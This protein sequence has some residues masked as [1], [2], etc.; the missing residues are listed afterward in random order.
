VLIRSRPQLVGGGIFISLPLVLIAVTVSSSPARADEEEDTEVVEIRAERV[1][2][3]SDLPS[4]LVTVVEAEDL[5]P[6]MVTTSMMAKAAPAAR[7]REFGGPGQQVTV[8]L[9]GA[10]PHQTR[11]QIDGVPLPDPIGTGVD[12][13]FIPAAFIERLEVLRGAASLQAGSGALGGVVN[14]ITPTE[15]VEGFFGRLSAGSYNTFNVSAGT[16]FES[17]RSRFLLAAS[18]LST[19]G[20]FEYLDNRLTEY[21]PYDDEWRAREN[22]DVLR[23]GLLFKGAARLGRGAELKLT[24]QMVAVDRGVAGLQGFTAEAARE[25]GWSGL[26]DLRAR[27]P[28]ADASLEAGAN[29]LLTGQHFEDPRG[30]LTGAPIDSRQE[31]RY[32]EAFSSGMLP[33]GQS[34]LLRLRLAYRH[35]GL[36]DATLQD[37]DRH[38]ICASSGAELVLLSDTV[39]I[40]PAV[41][42]GYVTGAGFQWA[43]ALGA[44]AEVAERLFLRVNLARAYRVP[45]FSEL[46][47]QGGQAVGNPDL[48][49]ESVWSADAGIEWTGLDNWRFALAGFYSRYFDLIVFE[50]SSNFRYRPINVGQAEMGGLEWEVSGEVAEGL[51]VSGHYTLL[52][53]ADRT[54]RPNRE[55]KELPGRPRH[56]AGLRAWGRWRHLL[57]EADVYFVSSNFVNQANT[58]ELSSRLLIDA[59]IGVD[60][61]RGMKVMLQAKNLLDDQVNDVRGLPLPGIS[62]FITVGITRGGRT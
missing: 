49:P 56:T 11:V 24:H 41:G 19:S 13:S 43:P 51:E 8:G 38:E 2:E 52:L 31:G 16:A 42:V 46:Y 32:L 21:N 39:K 37:P 27:L 36:S 62:L 29:L 7:V 17:G 28:V 22:N 6:G 53:T 48:E 25:S 60:A 61:G 34:H 18:G 54:G 44:V 9:R 12:L 58:K 57:A 3:V 50:P 1:P 35:S 55:G 59:G 23:G 33:L 20:D 45:N 30:E 26:L 4:S 15:K 10:A 47:L 5:G 40:V 14:L